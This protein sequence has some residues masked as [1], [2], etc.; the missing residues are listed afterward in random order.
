M[1]LEMKR[2]ETDENKDIETKKDRAR[3]RKNL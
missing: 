2:N 1:I 3:K